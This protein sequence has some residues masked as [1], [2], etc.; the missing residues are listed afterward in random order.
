LNIRVESEESPY[1]ALIVLDLRRK[2]LLK[3][4][5]CNTLSAFFLNPEPDG[6]RLLKSSQS[7]D[8]KIKLLAR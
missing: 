7:L 8:E 3:S 1:L 5:D 6:S 4:E 2:C